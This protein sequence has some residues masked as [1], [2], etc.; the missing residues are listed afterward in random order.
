MRVVVTRP[1]ISAR[2]TA[3]KL[4]ALGHEPVLLP[5]AKAIHHPDMAERALETPHAALA[6]TS[7]EAIRM[8]SSLAKRPSPDFLV[9]AVGAATAEVARKAGFDNIRTGPGTGAELAEMVAGDASTFHAPLLYLAGT[10]RSAKFEERLR[11]GNIPFATAEIYEMAQVPHDPETMRSLLVT[12]PAE[13]VLLYSKETARI[14]FELAAPFAQSFGETRFFCLS[15]N[16]AHGV[17]HEFHG[18]IMIARH[19]DE[20]GLFALL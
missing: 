15:D 9:Y 17:P 20:E 5:L 14:F 19:P 4:Q 13:A 16:V 12:S 6:V 3:R 11:A 2:Q 8:L 7:A 18:N 10:P 1:E